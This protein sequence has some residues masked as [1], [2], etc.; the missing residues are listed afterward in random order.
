[1]STALVTNSQ[2]IEQLEKKIKHPEV[3]FVDEPTQEI[4]TVESQP[5]VMEIKSLS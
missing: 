5:S 3:I 2:P 4:I 1:M